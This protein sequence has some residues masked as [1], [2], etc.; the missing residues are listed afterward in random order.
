MDFSIDQAWGWTRIVARLDE[1]INF[2]N[3]QCPCFAAIGYEAPENYRKRY[4]KGE[5]PRKNI[6]ETREPSPEPKFASERRK[7]KKINN[8]ATNSN[9][10]GIYLRHRQHRKNIRNVYF[11]KSQ[12]QKNI[13]SVYS[14]KNVTF[15]IIFC[16]YFSRLVQEFLITYIDM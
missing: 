10:G 8:I 7:K 1:Y 9:K 14:G 11:C 2:Y 13:H 5:L 16:V 15:K 12:T 3:E 4:Y 6:F